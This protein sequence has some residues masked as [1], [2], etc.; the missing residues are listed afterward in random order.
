MDE[1]TRAF[2]NWRNQAVGKNFEKEI[3]QLAG[4]T[5][6]LLLVRQWP[7]VKFFKGGKSEVVDKGW[8][9][10]I[11]FY[12]RKHFMFDAK[13]TGETKKF[14]PSKQQID[15]FDRL[16]IAA[17]Y[18]IPAFYLV[19]WLENKIIEVFRVYETD[20]WP[21]SYEK[22]T[23]SFWTPEEGNYLEPLFGYLKGL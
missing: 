3:E 1:N 13:T 22:F 10:Y 21:V 11:A 8:P 19:N 16:V 18:G 6:G 23:G 5:P 20:T 12:S 15:Q 7:E 17:A 2:K 14:R 4:Y 9:D